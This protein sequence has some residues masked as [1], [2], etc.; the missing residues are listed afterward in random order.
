MQLQYMLLLTEYKYT[1]THTDKHIHK[2]S[3]GIW[4]SNEARGD[5][6]AELSVSLQLADTQSTTSVT[7]F[8]KQAKNVELHQKSG[9]V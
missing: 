8:H 6:T 2:H 7:A 3:V 9:K 4:G 1:H 5:N